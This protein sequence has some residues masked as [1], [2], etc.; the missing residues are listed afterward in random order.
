M[1]QIKEQFDDYSH[2]TGKG[3][4]YLKSDQPLHPSA[5]EWPLTWSGFIN[6]TE[7][8]ITQ[9]G[10][11]AGDMDNFDFKSFPQKYN[12]LKGQIVDWIDDKLRTMD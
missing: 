8:V 5:I 7:V 9:D 2:P 10:L 11:F 4:V 1:W 3:R 12:H 6:N